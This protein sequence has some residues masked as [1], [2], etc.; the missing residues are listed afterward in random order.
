MT[1]IIFTENLDTKDREEFDTMLDGKLPVGLA[2]AAPVMQER[3]VGA[4]MGAFGMGG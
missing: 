3:N 4:L 2:D 1:Y